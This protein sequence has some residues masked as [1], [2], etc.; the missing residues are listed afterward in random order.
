[1]KL[2]KLT[3]NK[4]KQINLNK[5]SQRVEQFVTESQSLLNPIEVYRSTLQN[6]VRGIE[7]KTLHDTWLVG[8]DLKAYCLCRVDLDADGYRVYTAYQLW[9]DPKHR[10]GSIVYKMIKFLRF[11]AQKQGFKRLYVIS[12]RLDHIKAYARGLGKGF[13]AQSVIFVKEF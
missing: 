9:I 3:T 13:Q 12:S 6:V 1:M 7:Q 11:Y 8:E 5:F 2:L 10:D 4:L